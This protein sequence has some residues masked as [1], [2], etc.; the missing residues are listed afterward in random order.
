[1]VL[2]QVQ[3]L[4]NSIHSLGDEGLQNSAT[5]VFH[6]A[7]KAEVISTGKCIAPWVSNYTSFRAEFQCHVYRTNSRKYKE[8]DT[9][10][11]LKQLSATSISEQ[12]KGKE[13]HF[14]YQKMFSHLWMHS[15]IRKWFS[16]SKFPHQA[17]K[18]S[19]FL[20]SKREMVQHR[21]KNIFVLVA[22]FWQRMS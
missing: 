7:Q 3:L 14:Y 6:L 19:L 8:P 21:V 2:F 5:R 11:I 10:E 1:M 18:S 20:F 17:I 4:A 22:L 9:K 12:A 15:H 16:E 13:K